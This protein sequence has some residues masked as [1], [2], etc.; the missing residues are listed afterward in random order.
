MPKPHKLDWLQPAVLTGSLLPLALM[1]YQGLSGSL[2]ANPIATAL[3][4]LGML[5]LLFLLASLSCTPIKIV[6]GA[7]WPLRLR[8]TLGLLAFW[9]ALAHFLVYAVFDQVLMLEAIVEDIAERPFILLGAL[10][11]LCLTPLAITSTKNALRRMGPKRWQQLHRLAYV[12]G[13]LGVAHFLVRVKQ[14][15]TE[16]LVYAAI[17]AVLLAVR[18][19]DA[20]RR[21][22]AKRL[23]A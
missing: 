7:K 5:T 9:C 13:I 21:A 19:V 6:F 4:R 3:N 23:T 22:R 1:L 18:V 11:L 8:K 10:G 12:A 16:P 20:V 14:D 15:L 17:L 2:G